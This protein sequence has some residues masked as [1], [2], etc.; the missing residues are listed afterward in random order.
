[1][2]RAFI[3]AMVD[4]GNGTWSTSAG[5][6]SAG[7]ALLPPPEHPYTSS[8]MAV[9]GLT[10]TLAHEVGSTARH[11]EQPLPGP[12]AGPR[13]ARN[14]AA[15]EAAAAPGRRPSG[16]GRLHLAFRAP[17]HDH[18]GR[19]RARGSGDAQHARPLRCG[20]STCRRAS[21]PAEGVRSHHRR[22]GDGCEPATHATVGEP[23]ARD[24]EYGRAITSARGN[25]HGLWSNC[26]RQRHERPTRTSRTRPLPPPPVDADAD[27]A[28]RRALEDVGAE[29][30]GLPV[31]CRV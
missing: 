17:S 7:D 26:W 25:D 4:R 23:V 31:A 12:V 9:I 5:A 2:C 22:E 30:G 19:G 21:S 28:R 18:R 15:L 13:I 24:R 1:M 29:I 14:V 10:T 20:T 6:R 16:G 27:D 3:P 11:C 8:K